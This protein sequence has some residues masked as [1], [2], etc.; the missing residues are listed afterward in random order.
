MVSKKHKEPLRKTRQGVETREVK[1]TETKEP[2]IS[3]SF[4][5]FQDINTYPAQS[6]SQWEADGMLPAMLRSLMFITQENI[7]RLRIV[8]KKLSLYG[9]FPS[10]K[11]NEFQLPSSLNGNENW[12]TIRNIGG[13][14]PRIAGFLRDNIFYIVYLDKRHKFYKSEK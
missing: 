4:K 1:T 9:N 3:I 14:I 12:G 8:H 11:V 13:Q 10:K 2:Y 6:L 5:Y 7:T